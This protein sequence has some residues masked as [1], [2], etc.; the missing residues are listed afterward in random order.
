MPWLSKR[1]GSRWGSMLNL[2]VLVYLTVRKHSQKRQQKLR[3][4]VLVLI[5]ENFPLKQETELN[6]LF[7]YYRIKENNK[8]P[9]RHYRYYAPWKNY[10][11]I[12]TIATFINTTFGS[13]LLSAW[14]MFS[15]IGGTRGTCYYWGGCKCT[16]D[17]VFDR[18][19]ISPF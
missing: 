4:Q 12:R 16:G 14:A 19:Q 11:S 10:N 15:L 17:N 9:E 3:K 6:N 13:R 2:L 8:I 5:F 7:K 18:T 1:N